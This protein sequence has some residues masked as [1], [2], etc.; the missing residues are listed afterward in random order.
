MLRNLFMYLFIL[1]GMQAVIAQ[2]ITAKV[3]DAQSNDGLPYA[4][5]EVNGE[6]IVS[7]AEGGFAIPEKNNADNAVLTIS[8]LGYHT[9]RITV[10][11]LKASE[12]T[13]KLNPGVFELETVNITNIAPNGDSI[14][15]A[16][17]R[18]L[19]RNYNYKAD[20]SK[21]T[22]F[23]R[24]SNS[25]MPIKLNV[26]INKSSGFSNE[27]LKST[28]K[29]FQAL[30][31]GL[32]ARPPVEFKELICSYYKGVKTV[33]GKPVFYGKY[34]IVKGIK[35]K[36]KNR[37]VSINEMEQMATGI[38]FK[39]LDTTKYYRIKSG[40][41][42]SRDTIPIGVGARKKGKQ[43]TT[44]LTTAKSD[45]SVFL[46]ERSFLNSYK[47]DFV[48]HPELYNYFYEGAIPL[49]DQYVYI[50]KFSPKKS[51]A[52]YTGTLY[53]SDNDY[54]VVKA[55]YQL[56]EGKTLGGVNLK[57]LLGVKQ[58]ENVSSGTLIFKE[59]N[60]GGGYYLQYASVTSGEYM[61]LNRPLKFIEITKEEKDVV[62]F[63]LK[64]ETNM[65]TRQ[66]YYS[67]SLSEISMGELESAKER[68]F[69]YLQ[70]ESYDPKI[71]KEYSTIEPLEEM[72]KF[73]ATE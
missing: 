54:A 68:E 39:H 25:F 62:A 8:F 38:L 47:N 2:S 30:T 61:Y 17:K 13:V 1:L 51:K 40:L 32:I 37:A 28:N 46:S 69:S 64:I 9:A 6:N 3:I 29:Q 7:N 23:Y 21:N 73:K 72:K 57:F 53:V 35:L 60:S 43:K 33:D 22:F 66:E 52:K 48:T 56:A 45:I 20:P 58:S 49:G 42:G 31:S 55:D 71:W 19:A 16:V 27:D 4:N 36:D 65:Q 34:D 41:F 12:F 59:R 26:E 5:I 70:L 24:E 44:E 18:N 14:I 10:A 50:L 11:E 15:A 63:D 67:M